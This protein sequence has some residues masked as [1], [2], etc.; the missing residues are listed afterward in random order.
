[1]TFQALDIKGEC[2]GFYKNGEVVYTEPT[3]GLDKTWNYTSILRGKDIQYAEIYA[4]GK[5][6]DECCPDHIKHDWERVNKKLKA[7]FAS[8]LEAKVSLKENCIFDL[9]PER[10]LKEYYDVK[11]TITDHVFETHEK[12]SEYEFFKRFNEF[13]SDISSRQLE[14]DRSWLSE[15]LWDVQAKRLWDKIAKGQTSIEYNMFGSVTGRLTVSD[16]SFPIL[17]L[18]KELR[19]VIK[20]TNDWFV[21]IDLNAAE[22]RTAL[23]LLNKPQIEGDLHEWS[24]NNIFKGELNRSEAKQ[25]A[26]SW[27]YN[28]Q[29]KLAIKYDAELNAFYNKEALKAMYWVDGVVQTPFHRHIPADE[30]HAISYLNQSTLIDLL[31]RQIIKVDDFLK[32]KTSFIPFLIHD[33]FVLDLKHE[34]KKYLPDIIKLVSDTMW[35]NFPVNIKIGSDFGNMKKIKIKV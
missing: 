28:S 30:H 29:S 3:E 8:F 4:A 19:S 25:T 2:V 9:I 15:K 11:C 32:D 16:S 23:A 26:T 34:E 22:L 13:V 14:L 10:Y 17:N 24:A 6:I 27:L 7:F 1:M 18:N 31:H 20:P 35:G 33:S 12:P 21:E 5:S